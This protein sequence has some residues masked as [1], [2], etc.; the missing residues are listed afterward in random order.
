MKHIEL[1]K[2]KFAIVDD[3]DYEWLSKFKW[4]INTLDGDDRYAKTSIWNVMT[5]KTDSFYM[6][7]MI[8]GANKRQQVDHINGDRLDNRRSNLRIC[9][10]KENQR[11]MGLRNGYSTKGVHYM[12]KRS[13]LSAPWQAYIT[14]DR[15]RKHLGYYE[16]ENDAQKAYNVAAIE[17]FGEFARTIELE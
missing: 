12:K 7:R 11:N 4:Q 16:T 13:H 1:T 6:H 8:V 2:G 9:L 10:G 5:K 14:V 17:Y 15:K 3:E